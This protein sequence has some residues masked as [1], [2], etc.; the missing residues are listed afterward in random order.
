M[1]SKAKLGFQKTRGEN[2]RRTTR[3]ACFVC[4][5]S[6]LGYELIKICVYYI[7]MEAGQ[8]NSLFLPR[9]RVSEQE[10]ETICGFK[11]KEEGCSVGA[12]IGEVFRSSSAELFRFYTW[13]SNLCFP[14]S[15]ET[16]DIRD[17]LGE[18]RFCQEPLWFFGGVSKEVGRCVGCFLTVLGM[19]PENHFYFRSKKNARVH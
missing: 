6:Q 17:V 11:M 15:S 1:V 18:G 16:C 7:A 10:F 13:S 5:I 19:L 8:K 2:W 3:M 14:P 4:T 12:S 9:K